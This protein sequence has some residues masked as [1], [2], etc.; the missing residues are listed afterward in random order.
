MS[1]PTPSRG[2]SAFDAAGPPWS[3]PLAGQWDEAV[4]DSAA[5]AGNPLGDPHLRPVLTYLPPG[6]GHDPDHRYPVVYFLRGF[7]GQVDMWR[8]RRAMSPNFLEQVDGLFASGDV[9][10]ALVV[11]VDGWTSWGGAQYIDS[12]A[13]GRYQ[14]Y[15]S[16]D[17][18]SFV[19]GRYHTITAPGG[20]AVAGHSSGGY[21][22][23][24]S[25]L[26]HPE[27]WGS[28]AS[29]AGDALFEVCYLP[30]FR[31]TARTLATHYEGSWDRWW[32]DVR[33]RGLLSDDSDFDLLNDWCM[34]ACYSSDEDG[35]VH[36]PFE[37]ATGQLR[38]EVWAQWLHWDP[39][40]MV[41]RCADAARS[42][43][44]V[45]LDAGTA[46]EVFLD[47]GAVAL[48]HALADVGVTE[49]K[50]HFE[51]HGGRHGNQEARFLASLAWLA[52]RLTPG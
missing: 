19:D 33:H 21:G 22:A 13:I 40:R 47:R 45:W 20:R 51:L 3:R 26:L 43:R 9:P 16:N 32:A 12:P 38:P 29:H 52:G 30:G 18:V 50:V 4:L 44:W 41:A 35:A 10:P 37:A 28:V 15:L 7:S 39:V 34:A 31:G 48:R 2:P 14:T 24:V 46:D 11:L 8:N 27:V 42:W 17:V 1:E 36:A 25:G 6:Y 23:V 5:L 49:P